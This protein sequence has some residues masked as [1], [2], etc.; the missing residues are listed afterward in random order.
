MRVR[1]PFLEVVLKPRY[2]EIEADGIAVSAELWG[3]RL[4]AEIEMGGSRFVYER[5]TWYVLDE[6]GR[7]RRVRAVSQE[8]ARRMRSLLRHLSQL[9][10]YDVLSELISAVR[11]LVAD[12]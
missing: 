12:A 5:G 11:R 7:Q 6:E 4:Y 10:R 2:M 8:D 3:R 1:A 9:P